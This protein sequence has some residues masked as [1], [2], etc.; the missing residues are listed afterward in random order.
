MPSFTPIPESHQKVWAKMQVQEPEIKADFG[1]AGQTE[2]F[3]VMLPAKKIAPLAE[4]AVPKEVIKKLQEEQTAE[5]VRRTEQLMCG[6]RLFARHLEYIEE[7][8]EQQRLMEQQDAMRRMKAKRPEERLVLEEMQ[9][10][11]AEI[12]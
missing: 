12:Y 8:Q 11:C 5:M 1:S 6:N 9:L 3:H 7:M 4:N 2:Q 10:S